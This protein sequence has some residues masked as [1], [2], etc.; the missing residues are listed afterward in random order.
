[1]KTVVVS[2][3][4]QVAVPEWV[5]D[6]D[7]FRRWLHSDEFPEEGRICFING[8]FWVDLSVERFFDHGQVKVEVSRVL[9]NLLKESRL[10]RFAPDGTRYTHLGTQLSTEPA[11][12]VIATEAFIARRVELVSGKRGKD[13]ELIGTPDVVIEIVSP[14]SVDKDTEWLMS[15]YYD[16]EIPEYWLIDARDGEIRFDIFRRG[17]R[18][19][20]ASRKQDGWVKSPMLGRSFRLVRGE[21]EAGN[22]EFTLHVR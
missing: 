7:S 21:D 1:M 8:T 12:L 5:V 16:A 19:Y 20:T 6:F 4:D 15:A 10:G 2:G 14:S 13:T 18:G 11:G 3:E 17:K 22:P 9:S